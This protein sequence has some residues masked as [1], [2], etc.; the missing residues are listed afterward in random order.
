MATKLG[1]EAK[2]YYKIGGVAAGGAWN[3]LDNARDVTLNMEA[4]EAD[5]VCLM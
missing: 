2:L 4:G 5:V 1:M 3:E